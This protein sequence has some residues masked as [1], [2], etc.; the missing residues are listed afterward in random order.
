[1]SITRIRKISALFLFAVV[2][3]FTSSADMPQAALNDES[4][5]TIN[6]TPKT[7]R[8]GDE[9]TLEI[10]I[11]HNPGFSLYLPDTIMIDPFEIIDTKIVDLKE[12]GGEFSK[13]IF[14]MAAYKVGVLSIPS[15]NLLL[16]SEDDR[17]EIKT[18]T[19]QLEVVSMLRNLNNR[20]VDIHPPLSLQKSY[21]KYLIWVWSISFI[22]AITAIMHYRQKR[23]KERIIIEP[24]KEKIDPN[25][26]ALELLDRIFSSDKLTGLS[27]Q[28]I[29]ESVAFTVKLYL[30]ERYEIGAMEMTSLE[31]VDCLNVFGLAEDYVKVLYKFLLACDLVKF[32]GK[33]LSS[34]K[35]GLDA[36]VLKESALFLVQNSGRGD[37][38]WIAK[39]HL[40]G[41]LL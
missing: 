21:L 35:S 11:K 7:V 4:M 27:E 16:K 14:K 2:F 29:C 22:L 26:M 17:V 28:E 24:P 33:T 10:F 25:K 18:P 38:V 39:N 12:K 6:I 19:R 3:F 9:I 41:R 36:Q 30:K 13:A 23:A 32:A 8:V 1:M 40:L 34:I 5:V 20:L 37:G 31:V 15:I